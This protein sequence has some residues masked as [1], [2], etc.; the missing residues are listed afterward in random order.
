[1]KPTNPRFWTRVNDQLQYRDLSVEEGQVRHSVIQSFL[2]GVVDEPVMIYYEVFDNHS[3]GYVDDSL[4]Q[5]GDCFIRSGDVVLDLGANIGIFSRFA[6]DKGASKVYSFEPTLENF[7]LLMLNR[8]ENCEAHRIAICDQDNVALQI[9]YKEN[10]PGG[11]SIVRLEGGVLQ[12]CMGMTV[13]TMIDRQIIQQPDFIKM[14]IEGAEIYAFQGIKDEHL[15]ATRCLVM[16]MHLQVVGEEAAN[17]IYERM[18]R[19]GFNHFTLFNPDQCN[20]IWFTN[21]KIR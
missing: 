9:S 5:R 10:C 18:T 7:Q 8:P 1:M 11:S 14:D 20:I 12:T 4:Y 17:K 2:K 16:E 15:L 13:S 19:L 21:T 3:S 6:S